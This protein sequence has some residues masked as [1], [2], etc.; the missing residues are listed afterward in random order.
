ML[1]QTDA[2]IYLAGLRGQF[3]TGG[4][5]SF[6]TFNFE[7]YNAVGREPFGGL[8][9]FNDETL[10]PECENTFGTDTACQVILLPMIGAIEVTGAGREPEFANSGEVLSLFLNPGETFRIGN[11]YAGEAVNYLQIRIR[12]ERNIRAPYVNASFDLSVHNTL[13]PLPGIPGN[14]AHFF[15]GKYGGRQEGIFTSG[16]AG[17][18]A[19]VFVIEGAFEVQDRLLEKHDG[20]ALHHTR[21]I[22]FE[23][24]S[25]DAIILFFSLTKI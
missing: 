25:N 15:I 1:T 14:P 8:L 16:A 17:C 19:F 20:L 3:Q 13:L 22:E 9:A 4:F 12:D 6:R 5:R 7:E 18:S 24:L 11:P 21:E 10:L 2:R 23:A